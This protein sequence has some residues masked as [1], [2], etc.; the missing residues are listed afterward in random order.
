MPSDLVTRDLRQRAVVSL[1][2]RS[3]VRS[4]EELVELLRRRGL[5]ATQPSVSRDLR[6]LGVTKVGGRYFA[7]ETHSP[8]QL[9]ELAEAAH[10]LRGFKPAGPHL[11]VVFTVVGAAQT[12]ALAIDHAA[13]PEVVGTVAGDDTIFVATSAARDQQ[14]LLRR[15]GSLIQGVAR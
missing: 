3:A 14:R 5:E 6:D 11:A 15:L 10:Y 1:L 7:P 2:K 4:Q 8:P 12:V 13:W 9:Q